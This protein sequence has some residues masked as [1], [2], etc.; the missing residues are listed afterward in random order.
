HRFIRDKA[1]FTRSDFLLKILGAAAH[2]DVRCVFVSLRKHD[3]GLWTEYS[4][5]RVA[6]SPDEKNQQ[7]RNDGGHWQ[8]ARVQQNMNQ[9]NVHNN[10]SKQ[11][12]P[13]RDE[14]SDEQEQ[15]ADDLE[16]GNDVKVMAQE[17]R[18][19]EVSSQR[20]RWRWHRN[21]M[22]K[23]VRTE[24]DENE[25]E[26]NPSNNCGDFHS[27]I[28]TWLIENSNLEFPVSRIK[29]LLDRELISTPF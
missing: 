24:D 18:L 17:K 6:V 27:R 22:Q 4:S 13:K 16:Y 7:E 3:S 5:E 15:A 26:K 10:G 20:W 1:M 12:Q 28:V 25:S 2:D 14:A 21:E 9:I 29:S 11:N 8:T 23:D 19:G